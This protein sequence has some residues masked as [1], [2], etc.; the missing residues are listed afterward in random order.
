MIVSDYQAAWPDEFHR[1]KLVLRDTLGSLCKEVHHVG[2]TAIPAL[3]AKPVLD[4][5]VELAPPDSLAEVSARLSGLGYFYQG[6]LGITDR[7]AYG[8]SSETVPWSTPSRQWMNHH[9]YVC[10]VGS[11]ELARHL[12]FRDRLRADA[13]LRDEYRAIKEQA[14]ALAGDDR[15][16]YVA[17]KERLGRDF[18]RRVLDELK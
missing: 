6:E 14:L 5:D 2:S 9:L 17:E 10:P 13:R 1:I 15:S 11:R 12:W 18:F 8:R 16:R 4:I 7:H 3:A